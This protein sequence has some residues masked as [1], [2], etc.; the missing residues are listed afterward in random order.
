M[1]LLSTREAAFVRLFV[2]GIIVSSVLYPLA[3]VTAEKAELDLR[4]FDLTFPKDGAIITSTQMV[5]LEW[6][7]SYLNDDAML[8]VDLTEKPSSENLKRSAHYESDEGAIRLTEAEKHTFGNLEYRMHPG[9]RFAVKYDVWV[10]E[11]DNGGETWFYVYNTE[12]PRVPGAS[13]GGYALGFDNYNNR[14]EFHWDG[15]L[16]AT[17]DDDSFSD[18]SWHNVV[19]TV[20]GPEITLYLDG[21]RKLSYTDTEERDRSG[22][23]MGW[24]A[25]CGGSY[26]QQRVR[27]LSVFDT[28]DHYE[29]WMDGRRLDTTQQT[30]YE[31]GPL[32]YG[33][34]VWRVF[35]V[36]E[37]GDRRE[38]D[39]TGNISI[40]KGVSIAL[41]GYIQT[42]EPGYLRETLETWRSNPHYPDCDFT[43]HVGDLF[44][45]SDSG[46]FPTEA[47]IE[48]ATESYNR[49]LTTFSGQALG[50]PG[51][52]DGEEDSEQ[53]NEWVQ[54]LMNELGMPARTFAFEYD[55]VL[56]INLGITRSGNRV[57]KA[58]LA[59]ID[60]LT[61]RH[62]E[63]PTVFFAPCTSS[64]LTGGKASS[65]GEGE[66]VSSF[67]EDVLLQDQVVGWFHGGTDEMTED[68][69][70]E[71]LGG[72][73]SVHH[74]NMVEGGVPRFHDESS[75][76]SGFVQIVSDAIHVGIWDEEKGELVAR[77]AA[78]GYDLD[79]S[80]EGFGS[81]FIPRPVQD[82]EEW[83]Y[84]N[85]FGARGVALNLI[86][87]DWAEPSDN[88]DSGKVKDFTI[89][90]NGKEFS[91][92][93]PLGQ[94]ET[95]S[96]E[97]DPALVDRFTP[98]GVSI[99]DNK[100]GLMEIQ[101]EDPVFYSQHA[102]VGIEEVTGS[103][104]KVK[105][106]R[107]AEYN[108]T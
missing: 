94:N 12:S 18:A 105:L 99:A 108:E 20:D 56:F 63:K 67:W 51:G 75:S 50:E 85:Y 74:E 39:R 100:G 35:S 22:E 73:T 96:F 81:I 58:T 72:H 4:S 44:G 17:A 76:Y 48:N 83:E 8:S 68:A 24:G 53:V 34:H 88:S 65:Q 49:Y 62:P 93:E 28:V 47:A 104:V 91:A 13:T 21:E 59:W 41:T 9:S 33:D 87:G 7:R 97:I 26:S 54:K 106:S 80:D 1:S 82:G 38:M 92:R 77:G 19:I 37:D 43:F 46:E 16:V 78:G 36:T 29:V 89:T 32:E 2:I 107:V 102:A 60:S 90:F 14:I 79:V 98:I 101:Y 15:E 66:D 64:E 45:G 84:T 70:E 42:E 71:F 69:A 25:R 31:A 27:N 6:E 5:R 57:E 61:K 10:G 52:G 95:E 55:N 3:G 40:R 23:V 86:G 11:E 30:S 103:Q